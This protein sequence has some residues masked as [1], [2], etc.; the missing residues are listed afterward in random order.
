MAFQPK[1]YGL[2]KHPPNKPSL[3]SGILRDG[4]FRFRIGIYRFTVLGHLDHVPVGFPFLCGFVNKS[5]A[6]SSTRY[7]AIT[8]VEVRLIITVNFNA[9]NLATEV[10]QRPVQHDVGIVELGGQIGHHRAQ[11]LAVVENR[12]V[13]TFHG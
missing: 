4:N 11:T 1:L 2:S 12:L 10:L 5:T 6:G 7:D 13:S 9:R 3:H 8:A